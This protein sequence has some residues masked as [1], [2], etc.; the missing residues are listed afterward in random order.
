M[1]RQQHAKIGTHNK[2]Y[3]PRAFRRGAAIGV[4]H[5]KLNIHITL[6]RSQW[7]IFSS[8]HFSRAGS[9]WSCFTRQLP[10]MCHSY[11]GGSGWA[12]KDKRAKSKPLLRKTGWDAAGGW[13]EGGPGQ[14]LSVASWTAPQMAMASILRS[15]C[16]WM[17]SMFKS[18][19]K[20]KMDQGPPRRFLLPQC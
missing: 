10:G 9:G 8:H 15:S 11:T 16:R 4:C 14:H 5:N 17:L 19:E 1:E 2:R 20:S 18:K 7:T 6:I 13:W 12:G 3:L